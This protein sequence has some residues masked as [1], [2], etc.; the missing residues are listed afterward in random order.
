MLCLNTELLNK[1]KFIHPNRMKNM[2][3]L[4]AMYCNCG[5]ECNEAVNK[6]K[7]MQMNKS[8]IGRLNFFMGNKTIKGTNI[9][10]KI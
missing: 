8:E 4:A 3:M 1:C 9:R 6:I 5:I 2:G 7:K 10:G